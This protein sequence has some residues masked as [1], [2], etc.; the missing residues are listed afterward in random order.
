VAKSKTLVPVGDI[1]RS[2]LV[3]RGQRVLLD[4]DLAALYGVVTGA[5][6]QAVKHNIARFPMDFV[7]QLTATEWTALRSQ[8]VISKPSRGGRRFAPMRS[9]SKASPC[10]PRFSVANA[11]SPPSFLPFANSWTHLPKRPASASPPISRPKGSHC[12]HRGEQ[13]FKVANC[14]QS[15]F[16]ADWGSLSG[17]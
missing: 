16:V 4:E 7:F 12:H 6:I 17:P 9:L 13:F 3:L 5:L 15:Y 14:G 1:T 8:T 10:S 2:I 11:P